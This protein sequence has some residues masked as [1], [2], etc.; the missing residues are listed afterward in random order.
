MNR[1]YRIIT[2]NNRYREPSWARSSVEFVN[3]A[4]MKVL[5]RGRDLIHQ[6][7][8]L[9]NHPLYGNFRPYQQPFRTLLLAE[10]AGKGD[11]DAYS[12]ELIA[13]A[14]E[15]YENCGWPHI[16]PEQCSEAL[17]EDCATIDMAL[18]KE[19]LRQCGI[20]E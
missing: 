6:G 5:L 18:M 1:Q 10:P 13:N 14:I 11:V 16:L 7:W 12:L 15:V 4:A 19:T 8:V 3:F 2:N 20:V 17:R 9:Q